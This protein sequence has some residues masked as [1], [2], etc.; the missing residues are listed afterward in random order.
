MP[1]LRWARALGA[2]ALLAVL[3]ASAACG[4]GAQPSSGGNSSGLQVIKI[5]TQSPLS[6]DESVQG[7]ALKNGAAL[8]LKQEYDQFKAMGFDLQLDPQDDK[9]D[10]NTGVANAQK[11]AAD[12]QVLA[13]VGHLDSGV[14]IPSEAQY[15]AA[16]LPIVS[17][18]NTNPNVTSQ[19]K[20]PEIS[21]ICGRDDVQGPVGAIFA[22]DQLGVKTVFVIDNITAYGTGVA[23][24]FKQKAQEIGLQ[25]VGSQSIDK[26]ETDYSNVLTQ[27]QQV[28][29]DLVY[30]GGLY[31]GFALML[32]Q[33]AVRGI[34]T[35]WMGPDGV[36]SNGLVATAKENAIGV[37]ATSVAA[38]TNLTPGGQKFIQ[39]YTAEYKENPDPYAIYGYDAMGVVLQGLKDAIQKNGG[40]LPTRAQVRDAIRA[41]TDYQGALVKVGFDSIGDNIYAGYYVYQITSAN[42]STTGDAKLM[43]QYNPKGELVSQ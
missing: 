27:I 32:N 34:H 8:K 4:G 35:K 5:A 40:K 22:K 21:R 38:P 16:Q 14:M 7:I 23:N 33:A 19:Y 28:K 1:H 39:D 15:H 42:A 25:V 18:A 12:S 6:G 43:A 17:P 36:F 41:I 29:P 30:Y 13:V 24:A 31:Q 26:S 11:L 2:S 37:Y 20:Y 3:L 9:G 10:P